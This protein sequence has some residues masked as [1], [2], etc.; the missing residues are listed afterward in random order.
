MKQV[1]MGLVLLL[2]AGLAQAGETELER[3][4]QVA[5]PPLREITPP[6]QEPHPTSSA[7]KAEVTRRM[8]WL[9]LL[10]R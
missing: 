8:F 2:A 7:R 6:R 3:T 1:W 4:P 9:V 5:K 10:L